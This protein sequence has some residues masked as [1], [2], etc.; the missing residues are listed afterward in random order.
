MNILYNIRQKG[1][2][3]I[4]MI[5]MF[6]LVAF[7]SYTYND[8]I[9]QIDD[10]SSEMYSDR[11]IA[12]NYIYKLE[13]ILCQRKVMI[14]EQNATKIGDIF[15]HDRGSILGL[16]NNYEKT[17]LTKNEKIQFQE[18][19][20]NVLLMMN[21]EQKYLLG[22]NKDLKRNMLKLQ[23]ESL[24]ISL[25][26]LDKLAETQMSIG[27]QLNE[28]SK[29]IVTFSTLLNQFDLAIIIIIGLIIQ[30]IIFTSRS[31]VPKNA[32]NQFLN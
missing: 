1:R 9:G 21:F 32:Q 12:Q 28:A 6:F 4:L 24:N 20:K 27:K 7:S 3:T 31:A 15:K 14:A 10:L 2:V 22:G 5:L 19:K 23:S 29:K 25:K 18:L 13:K 26:Q 17:K 16:L 30:G 8:N 11:L